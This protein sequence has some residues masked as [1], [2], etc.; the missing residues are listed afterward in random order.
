MNLGMKAIFFTTGILSSQI[1]WI[2]FYVHMV[3]R[4]TLLEVMGGKL[5]CRFFSAVELKYL[6]GKLSAHLQPT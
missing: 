4:G 6:S 2:I 5:P 1:L 3:F